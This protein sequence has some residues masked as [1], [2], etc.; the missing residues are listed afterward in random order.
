MTSSSISFA[1]P[2]AIPFQLTACVLASALLLSACGGGDPAAPP[3]T[4]APTIAVTDSVAAATASGPVT[5]TFAF[6]KDVGTTFTA[7]NITVTGGT[8]GMF[9]RVSGTQ[10]TLVVTPQADAT[11]T[12][13]VS[14]A[15]LKV[16]DAAGNGNSAAASGSQAYDTVVAVVA[17]KIV[18]FDETTAPTLTGFGGAEDASVVADPTNAANKV[19]KI[20]KSATAESWA[21]ATISVCANQ[22]V[23][24]LPF[25]TANTKMTARVW[26]PDAGIPVRMKVESATDST[27]SVETEA[28]TTVASGW[29][30]LTFNFASQATGTAALNVA[31]L[32]NKA[33][34]FFN[35]GKTGA[36]AGAAKTYYLDDLSFV[37]ASF[38]ATCAA[39][40]TTPAPTAAMGSITF[41]ETTAPVLTGFGGADD[42]SVVTDP[43]NAANKVAKVV[44]SATAEVWAGTTVSTLANQAIAAINFSS[45]KVVTMRVWSPDAGIPV[46]LKVESAADGT[47]SL[48]TE[49]MTTVAGAWQTLS[50]NFAALAAG[51]GAL[52]A[53]VTYN[54][55]SVF[56]NFGKSGAQVGA[57]KTYYFDD[58]SYAAVAATAAPS[59]AAVVIAAFDSDG[60][61]LVG[62][63]GTTEAAVVAD[64]AG[65]S[66]KVGKMVKA[67]TNVAPWAGATVATIDVGYFDSVTNKDH[68]NAVTA[69]PF[70]S[71]RQKLTMRVYSPAA[72]VRVHM[73]VE[74]AGMPQYNCETDAFTTQANQ[75]ETLTF[76]FADTST[77]YIPNGATTYDKTKPTVAKLDLA[78]TF[79]KVSVF[80]DYFLG[81]GAS[82]YARMPGTR[83]YYFDDLTLAK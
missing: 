20:V 5:F 58:V 60:A 39:T 24:T 35:F 57:A 70:T 67:A 38:T 33:S 7:E 53:S 61:G 66:N 46:R 31:T 4:V 14:V 74:T 52:D 1:S 47:K 54:K 8:A 72:G 59:G 83:T 37:G 11:G 51:S 64:P 23:A 50:F 6:S 27:K 3:D 45:S 17:S 44:K 32:Y 26:S 40:S 77:H 65:G 22:A 15:A 79:N 78:Q 34:V 21:G 69:I 25:S 19:A 82:A 43:T 71:S 29:Q 80:F 9:T 76:D 41:D 63:E 16:S 13:T 75:W 49:A 28:T 36:Q 42:S 56:F 48:E 62:F 68:L 12:I 81:D 30:T 2:F 10:A 18:T 73:K 55:A